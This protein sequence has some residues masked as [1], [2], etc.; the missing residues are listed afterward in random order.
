MLAKV[1][2]CIFGLE[3]K[4]SWQKLKSYATLLP[5]CILRKIV[6]FFTASKISFVLHI[7]KTCAPLPQIKHKKIGIRIFI[8]YYTDSFSTQYANQ[9]MYLDTSVYK[10]G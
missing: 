10:P 2:K 3:K 6:Q 1:L 9:S 4:E 8:F 7:V 5:D